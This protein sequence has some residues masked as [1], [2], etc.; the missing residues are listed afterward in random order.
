M[1]VNHADETL[2]CFLKKTES[3]TLSTYPCFFILDSYIRIIPLGY[4]LCQE[5]ALK[6]HLLGLT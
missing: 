2:F 5:R 4:D 6:V 3:E 1:Q